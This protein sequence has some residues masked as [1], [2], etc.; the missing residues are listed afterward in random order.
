MS[1]LLFRNEFT[2]RYAQDRSSLF[3][4]RPDTSQSTQRQNPQGHK[5]NTLIP[6]VLGQ[7][8]GENS[9]QIKQTLSE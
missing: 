2:A 7:L 3:E 5:L 4:L 8:C 1:S 9:I 6:C